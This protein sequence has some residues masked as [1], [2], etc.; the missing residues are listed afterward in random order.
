MADPVKNAFMLSSATLMITPYGGTPCFDLVPATHSVGMV[1]ELAINVESG[2]IDLNNGVAQALVDS[3]KTGVSGTISGNV[4]EYTAQNF[5][6]SQGIAGTPVQI[7]RG[8]LTAAVA[9]AATTASINSSPIPGEAASAITVLGDL[10]SGATV[11][12]QDAANP[13]RLFPTRLSA[14]TTGA[15]PYVLTFAGNYA[16]P[17]GMSFAIGDYVWVVNEV[18]VADTSQDNLVSVKAVGTLAN[19]NRPVVCV[20]PKVRVVKGFQLSFSETQ[21][22]S[23]PW[24]MRPLLLTSSEATGR[25]ADIGTKRPGLVYAG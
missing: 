12:F 25:L 17:A 21:Y 16:I 6:Y 18:G 10:P 11:I 14:A 1:K 3:R 24:E 4:Y 9:G 19:F 13:D 20:F 15:G 22:G 8:I 23:M 7:K 2:S 5:M